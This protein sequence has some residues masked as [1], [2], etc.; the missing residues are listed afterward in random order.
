MQESRELRDLVLGLYRDWEVD[1]T[2]VDF[3]SEHPD[4]VAV[5]TDPREWW[6]GGPGIRAIIRR[7][8]EELGP[9][10]VK[11][12]RLKAFVEGSVGWVHD[13]PV[14]TYADGRQ[15]A[16]RLTLVLHREGGTWKVVQLHESIGISNE[17]RGVEVTTSIDAVAEL[18]AEERP[19]LR[20]VASPEGTITIMFTDIESSTA[21]NESV[22][23]AR[24][25]AMLSEHSRILRD[26]VEAPEDGS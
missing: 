13:D 14:F 12:G 6:V 17:S 1:R 8:S 11:P 24:W 7:Q 21:V 15:S 16:R 9:I 5:A 10:S 20:R 19:D 3:I 25:I 26:H 2:N 18:V 22:G 23:D 4:A